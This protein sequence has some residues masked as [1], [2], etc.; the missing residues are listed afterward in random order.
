MAARRRG[1]GYDSDGIRQLRPGVWELRF[2]LG[3]DPVLRRKDGRPVYRQ[4]SKT[5]HGTKTEA[6]AE[7][8]RLIDATRPKTVDRT[9]ATF[10]D[11]FEAWLADASDLAETTVQGHRMLYNRHIR[12]A[13]GDTKLR[14]L[15]TRQ[16]E[17]FYAALHRDPPRGAGL[18]P[19]SIRR[20]HAVINSA[21][22]RA[23]AW[24]WL[25]R[26]PAEFARPPRIHGRPDTYTPTLVE[27]QR[28]LASALEVG[29]WALAFIWTAA[30]TGMRRGELCGLQWADIDGPTQAIHV[31]RNIVDVA[32]KPREKTPKTGKAR[33]VEIP[34]ELVAVLAAYQETQSAESPWLWTIG[35]ERVK[36]ERLTDTWNTVRAKAEIP[37]ECRLHDLRHAYG[38]IAV[39]HGGEQIVAAVA[40]QLGHSD[41]TTTM[42]N[43]L[44]SMTGG[45]RRAADLMGRLLAGELSSETT[46]AAP[47]PKG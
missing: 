45:R 36:P 43:Y 29:P 34:V 31:R 9:D 22:K 3:P 17:A 15:T 37:A 44:T 6:R 40:D 38:T 32:G 7:R 18:H 33:R 26:N 42:R 25:D 23:M 14:E 24:E 19:R 1:G 4:K 16:L 41:M 13:I 21:L 10:T 8:Q 47:P 12:P 2:S 46:K 11:L 28:A 20:V 27:L 39:E 30:A 5:F 35:G